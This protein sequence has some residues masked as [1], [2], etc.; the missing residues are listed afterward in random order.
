LHSTIEKP[1]TVVVQR[2]DQDSPTALRIP[3]EHRHIFDSI[4]FVNTNTGL[5]HCHRQSNEAL[6]QSVNEAVVLKMSVQQQGNFGN[7]SKKAV[8]VKVRWYDFDSFSA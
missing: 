2:R 7:G 3:C 5:Q 8:H 1:L 4:V 6:S